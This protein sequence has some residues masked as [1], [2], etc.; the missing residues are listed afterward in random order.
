MFGQSRSRCCPSLS[1]LCFRF[2]FP[3]TT[4]NHKQSENKTFQSPNC[5][6]FFIRFFVQVATSSILHILFT[7]GKRC[8]WRKLCCHAK[9]NELDKM[10]FLFYL[11]PNPAFCRAGSSRAKKHRWARRSGL[12]SFIVRAPV[13]MGLACLWDWPTRLHIFLYPCS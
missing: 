1:I 9:S 3:H 2:F 12:G 4:A 5:F 10:A 13:F 6:H 7:L 8:Y 11:H